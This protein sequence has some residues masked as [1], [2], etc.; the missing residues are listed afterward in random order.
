VTTLG[1][2]EAGRARS[3]RR[4][5]RGIVAWLLGLL[6]AAGVFFAGLAVGR[7]LEEAPQPGGTQTRVRTL[8]P[9]TVA[10]RERTVTVTTAG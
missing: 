4:R 3:R 10:P 7:A 5:G 6:I 1:P 9:L 8:E 2:R